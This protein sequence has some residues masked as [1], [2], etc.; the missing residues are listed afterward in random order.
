MVLRKP[1]SIFITKK[2][3]LLLEKNVVVKSINPLLVI[4]K[5]GVG[6]VSINLENSG[7]IWDKSGSPISIKN[8]QTDT[9]KNKS[10]YYSEN[11]EKRLR[12]IA[13]QKAEAS[14]KYENAKKNIKKVITEIQQTGGE[15]DVAP[16]EETVNDILNFLSNNDT[17][18]SYLSKEI[19][20]Y[21]DYLYNH[22]VNVCT[23]GTAVLIRFNEK[24]GDIINNYLST[25]SI[26]ALHEKTQDALSFIYYLPEE[27]KDI[28]LG[29]FLHDIGKV[30]IPTEVLNKNGRLS[31]KEFQMVKKHSYEKGIHLLETNRLLNPY[32]YNSVKYH[33]NS[34]FNDEKGCYPEDKHPIELPIYVKICKLADIYDAMTSKRCYKEAFNPVGVVT[35]VYRKYAN[36]DRMLQ[37][38]L[39]AFV[40]IVGIYPPGSVVCLNNGQLAMIIDSEGPI[41]IPFTDDK[42]ESLNSKADPLDLSGVERFN[43][44][45][46]IDRRAALKTPLEVYDKLPPYLKTGIDYN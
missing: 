39:R 2:G 18:F 17:A 8:G 12:E 31:D 14:A 7:G 40:S 6:D 5:F 15:F 32:I 13:A 4:K 38:I 28:S 36:K 29:Y 30:L 35:E 1:G 45:M 46:S 41:V 24:F 43:D 16:V 10:P 23:I 11:V 37:F 22:S 19:F 25:I 34:V 42:G 33:H 44:E 20:S 21:D 26:E 27:V 9:H 3:V